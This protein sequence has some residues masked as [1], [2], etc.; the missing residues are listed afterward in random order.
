MKKYL[1]YIGKSNKNFTHNRFYDFYGLYDNNINYIS[2]TIFK[3]NKGTLKRFIKKDIDYFN[4]NFKFL[5]ELEYN[6]LQ[7]KL[8]LKKI[9][10]V[11]FYR[12]KSILYLYIFHIECIYYLYL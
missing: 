11:L 10:G 5:N 7:R 3:T 8:K 6:K 2:I 12:Y 4:K 9:S 1:L